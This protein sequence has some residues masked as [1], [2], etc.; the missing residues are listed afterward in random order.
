MRESWVKQLKC[1]SISVDSNIY[2]EDH[3]VVIFGRSEET[4]C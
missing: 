2:I 4:E 1:L 3:K